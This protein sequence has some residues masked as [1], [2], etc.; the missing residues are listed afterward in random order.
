MNDVTIASA[1]KQLAE[2]LMSDERLLGALPEDA[3][4]VLLDWALARLDAASAAADDVNAFTAAAAAIRRQARAEADAAADR[5]DDAAALAE[6]L[7]PMPAHLAQLDESA[8]VT[9]AHGEAQ[10][11]G[12]G[13]LHD[14]VVAEGKD[15]LVSAP[16]ASEPEPP[17][18]GALDGFWGR[19]RR[20]FAPH[21][22]DT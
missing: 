3:A 18:K 4:G 8:P 22:G 17:P 15:M 16:A 14:A 2:Q 1:H 6:R 13:R 5:G 11:C 12:C 21:R 9:A 20:F 19:L 10:T 7:R